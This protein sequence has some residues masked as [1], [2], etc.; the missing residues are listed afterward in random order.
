MDN[1]EN[2][3]KELYTPSKPELPQVD[4]EKKVQEPP[5]APPPLYEDTPPSPAIWRKV[6]LGAGVF[7]LLAVTVAVYV[8]FRGFYAFRKDRVELKLQGPTEITAGQTSVWKLAIVNKNETE[9]KDGELIFQFP[10]FSKPIIASSESSQFKQG[11]LKQT[12]PLAELKPGGLF[13]REFRAVIYGGENFER[14]AQAVFKFKPSS[15]S[16]IFESSATVATNITSL[17]VALAM[18]A[19]SET[20]SGEKMEIKFNLK[21]ESEA[22]FPNMRVRLEFPSGFRVEE[23]SEKLYEF[24]NVWRVDEFLPQESKGLV[25][26]GTVT[27]LEGENKVFRAFLEGLEGT[28]WKIY[29]EISGQVG[30]ITP[31]LSLYLN[32][33]P[34]GVTSARAGE[35]LFYKFVWQ[36]NL[37]A[38]LAN[39]TLK[40]KLDSD[41]FDF[42]SVEIGSPSGQVKN[43]NFNS[44]ARTATLN[45]DNFA[46]FF[47]I[48]PLERSELTLRVKIK[49]KLSSAGGKL[50]V[51]ATLD[52]TSK[53]EGLAVSQISASQSL[54]LEIKSGE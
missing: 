36:N 29:K 17:P 11:T 4:P 45:R 43:I 8:F 42:S 30:L 20:V 51:S 6:L 34:E 49:E 9:L 52:S 46:P 33:E 50:P 16:I 14:K 18:E 5:L 38:P 24:N 23:T 10:D 28:N 54:T 13:E 25:I 39:L 48:Q 44:S 32:T 47:G 19:V 31:P 2:L 41:N 26:K 15:G 27:G 7:L 3:Q 35:T 1:L 22:G 21:N 12:V 37:D 53:P 40:I